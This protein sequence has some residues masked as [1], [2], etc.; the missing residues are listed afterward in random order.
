MA[1]EAEFTEAEWQTLEKGVTGPGMLV[2]TAP[3]AGDA[4]LDNRL[5][6]RERLFAFGDDFWIENG[7]G[8][9]AYLVDGNFLPIRGSTRWI[10]SYCAIARAGAVINPVNAALTPDEVRYM[11]D[12]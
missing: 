2:A 5:K 4:G 10:V 11:I 12:N 7:R 8:Q 3:A 9:R 1:V 6:V